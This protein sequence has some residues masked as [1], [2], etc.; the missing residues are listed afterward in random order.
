[1]VN[2]RGKMT[3]MEVVRHFG[4]ES[5]RQWMRGDLGERQKMV[6]GVQVRRDE[7]LAIPISFKSEVR[8]EYKPMFSASLN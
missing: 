2:L 7:F 8:I 6:V 4:Y 1:M 5:V 3:I